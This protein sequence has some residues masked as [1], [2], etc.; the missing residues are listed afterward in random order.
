MC[1]YDYDDV[2]SFQSGGAG[3]FST[4]KDFSKLSAELSF[5]KVGILSRR[6][7]DF[8]RENGLTP[9]QRVTYNW[10][11]LWGYGYG[12]LVR[13]L[14]NHNA[15]GSMASEGAFG[16]DGWTGPY[17]LVD[18][19]EELS[20]TLFLQRA[21]AGTTPLSRNVVNAIYGEL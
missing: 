10:E 1:I 4:A 11:N 12:N 9:S 16:W 6:T 18:P 3:L 8:M 17:V 21:G 7:V 15:A 2:P 20:I 5:G 14:E 13:T 19:K